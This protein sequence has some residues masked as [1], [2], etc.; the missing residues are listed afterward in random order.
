MIMKIYYTIW[1]DCILIMKL[2]PVS[3]IVWK[4]FSVVF[5]T[6][7]MT[8]NLMFLDAIVERNILHVNYQL[9]IHFFHSSLLNNFLEWFIVF[10]FPIILFNYLLIFRKKRY[11]KLILKYKFH[12]GKYFLK[13]LI[14]SLFGPLVILIIAMILY[15]LGIISG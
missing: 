10:G 11:E 5:M 6:L 7:A 9:N 1:T 8:F 4:F 13:Y 15:H 3:K 14:I 2:S 12:N